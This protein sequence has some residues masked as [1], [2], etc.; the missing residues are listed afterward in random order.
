MAR[1]E[2]LPEIVWLNP[3]SLESKTA[4]KALDGNDAHVRSF[5][6][7]RDMPVWAYRFPYHAQQV[8]TVVLEGAPEVQGRLF[9]GLNAVAI[10]SALYCFPHAKVLAIHPS[11]E[12]LR[13]LIAELSNGEPRWVLASDDLRVG[14]LNMPHFT[15]AQQSDLPRRQ[16]PG[17]QDPRFLG[18]SVCNLIRLEVLK[19]LL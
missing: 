15:C 16:N 9:R 10:R 5:H 3:E 2:S 11:K 7:F 8:R 1:S 19:N 18:A 12:E 14:A 4:R 17:I 6:K 13:R